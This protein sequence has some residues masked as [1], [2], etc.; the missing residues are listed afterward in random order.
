MFLH[1]Q[2]IVFIHG[3]Q[4]MAPVQHHNLL[5]RCSVAFV[6]SVTLNQ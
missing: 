4:Q 5:S 1:T 3:Y 2:M 6:S